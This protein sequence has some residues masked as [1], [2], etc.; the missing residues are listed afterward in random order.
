VQL[1]RL[2]IGD[3]ERRVLRLEEFCHLV[4]SAWPALRWF[5]DGADPLVA[6]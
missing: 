6:E 4:S 3:A 5:T 1:A 2:E